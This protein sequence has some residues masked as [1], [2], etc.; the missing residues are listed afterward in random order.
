MP[1]QQALRGDAEVDV[2]DR[3]LRNR[4]A[5][6]QE[7]AGLRAG[8]GQMKFR[9]GRAEP[10]EGQDFVAFL[11]RD[12]PVAQRLLVFP[13]GDEGRRFHH[14]LQFFARDRAGWVVAAITP[15][16][17]QERV[18]RQVVPLD[19]RPFFPELLEFLFQIVVCHTAKLRIF[20][21]FAL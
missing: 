6:D 13:G 2:Q 18:Q 10:D 19:H 7:G 4:A 16:A 15:V 8:E 12:E 17:M 1:Q 9:Q 3:V 11:G 21:I 14:F 20:L 5:D